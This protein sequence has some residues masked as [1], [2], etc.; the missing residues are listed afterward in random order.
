[1]MSFRYCTVYTTDWMIDGVSQ[2][3]LSPSLHAFDFAFL[4]LPF[5]FRGLGQS[6]CRRLK[7]IC[8]P[9]GGVHA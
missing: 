4:G 5:D 2:I 3:S 6:L 9:V 8:G 1:M 7:N